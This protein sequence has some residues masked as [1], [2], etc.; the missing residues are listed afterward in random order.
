MEFLDSGVADDYAAVP[1]NASFTI[2]AAAVIANSATPA[3][4]GIR[5]NK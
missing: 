2:L 3:A 4:I 1:R 5:G